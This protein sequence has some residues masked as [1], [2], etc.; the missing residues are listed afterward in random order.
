MADPS[1][2]ES[3]Q[4]NGTYL[5]DHADVDSPATNG[6]GSVKLSPAQ[7]RQFD[8]ESQPEFPTPRHSRKPSTPPNRLSEGD[9][10]SLG[11]STA[12]KPVSSWGA[13]RSP[14]PATNGT[15]GRSANSSRASTPAPTPRIPGAKNL[16]SPFVTEH[17]RFSKIQLASPNGNFSS[18]CEKVTKFTGVEKITVSR[19]K[20]SEVVTFSITGKPENV[21]KAR[22]RLQNEV[23]VKVV[24]IGNVLIVESGKSGVDG[25][26]D[27]FLFKVKCDVKLDMLY[28]CWPIG[29]ILYMV[30][31]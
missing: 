4:L 7:Q 25:A 11:K 10:P 9:F 21:V 12:A 31:R 15:N 29:C 22:N 2:S 17:V 27:G 3:P 14:A 19:M 6:S 18:V 16:A 23:G 1:T 28:V 13:K 8:A 5:L 24:P 30:I 20:V 26:A